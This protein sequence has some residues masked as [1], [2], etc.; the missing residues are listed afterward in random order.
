M[1]TCDD[2]G[3]IGRLFID[4]NNFAE[5]TGLYD[6]REPE[7]PAITDAVVELTGVDSCND[8]IAGI[9]WPLLLTYDETKDRYYTDIAS[10]ALLKE[11]ERYKFTFKVEHNN[12]ISYYTTYR[13]AEHRGDLNTS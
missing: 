5:L 10:T 7:T 13:Y 3:L 8:L 11:N 6:P 12:R 9:I 1:S 2:G 4:S